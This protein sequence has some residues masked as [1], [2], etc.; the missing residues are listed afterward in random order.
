MTQSLSILADRRE[1]T[2]EKPVLWATLLQASSHPRATP[3]RPCLLFAYHAVDRLA[4]LSRRHAYPA[5]ARGAYLTR[6]HVPQLCHG[7]GY[8]DPPVV[9]RGIHLSMPR[10]AQALLFAELRPSGRYFSRFMVFGSSRFEYSPQAE[11]DLVFRIP[12]FVVV[13]F[14]SFHARGCFIFFLRFINSE[15]VNR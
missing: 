6:T 8:A 3:H 14:T 13:K 10:K 4:D 2:L 5:I 7:N 11:S 12:I 15:M 9:P 1:R